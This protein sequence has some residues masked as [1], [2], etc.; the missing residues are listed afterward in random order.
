MSCFVRLLLVV[1]CLFALSISAVPLA[2]AQDEH[3]SGWQRDLE[4]GVSMNVC[5]YP[6]GGSGYTRW[7]NDTNRSVRIYYQLTFGNGQTSL[8]SIWVPAN[9]QSDGS[10]CYNC[11]RRNGGV[12]SWRVTRSVHE[13]EPG[14]F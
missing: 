5:E 2:D 8:G 12:V 10:A 9:T 6:T 7:R 11:A 4:H 13:G 14:Y 3:C 1:T